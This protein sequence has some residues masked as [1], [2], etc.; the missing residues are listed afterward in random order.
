MLQ[1]D[2]SLAWLGPAAAGRGSAARSASLAARPWLTRGPAMLASFAFLRVAAAAVASDGGGGVIVGDIR[3]QALSATL[4][5]VEPRGPHGFE[6]RTTFMVTN[7]SCWADVPITKR[8]DG[9]LSTAFWDLTVRPV[10]DAPPSIVVNS[11]GGQVLYSSATDTPIPARPDGPQP[12]PC[13]GLDEAHCTEPGL[14]PRQPAH[15]VCL[16]HDGTCREL[17]QKTAPNLLHWPSPLSRSA[18]SLVDYPRFYVPEW[19]LQPA[20][21]T[22]DPVSATRVSQ[23]A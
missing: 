2:S 22:V 18:Y 4:L 12:S 8:P 21:R 19:D 14:S 3:V 6:D 9:T 15:W 5:R 20:P 10:A 7:R 1:R 11:R 23:A 17:N 13:D 16:W